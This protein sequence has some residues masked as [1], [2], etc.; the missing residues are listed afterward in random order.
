ML[1]YQVGT[2]VLKMCLYSVV[3]KIGR[4]GERASTHSSSRTKRWWL[5]LHEKRGKFHQVPAHHNAEQNLDAYLEHMLILIFS[6]PTTRSR[7]VP[8]SA[9]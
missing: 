7:P 6:E 8:D 4:F 9:T 1:V 3:R 5:R 2:G